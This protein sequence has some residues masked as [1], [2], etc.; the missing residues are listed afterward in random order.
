[1]CTIF[2]YHIITIAIIIIII[3]PTTA[4]CTLGVQ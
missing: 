1:M 3:A 4:T 2:L